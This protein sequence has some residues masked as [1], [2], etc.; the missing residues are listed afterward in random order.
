MAAQIIL[1]LTLSFDALTGIH[2]ENGPHELM[3]FLITA[4]G[5][6]I[7]IWALFKFNL[8]EHKLLALWLGLAAICCLYVAGEEVSWGQHF[9][10]W[11]TPEFWMHLNDQQ[12][13]NLHNVSSW[14]DQKPRL[15]LEIGILF[16]GIIIPLLQKY[17][18]ALVPAQFD[19]IYPPAQLWV[20][21]V[22]AIGGKIIV[23]I[24]ESFDV[25][26]FNR[27]SEVEELLLF[28]FVFLYLLWLKSKI[29]QGI[30]KGNL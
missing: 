16:G 2:S 23:K 25:I 3:Q 17:K 20:I 1:E 15:I 24:T 13:T 28:Y 7:A 8:K 27:F 26:L 18:P 6:I 29:E 30:S 12:E 10:L 21:A 5:A 19:F 14:F 11:S 4:L 9:A 22:L